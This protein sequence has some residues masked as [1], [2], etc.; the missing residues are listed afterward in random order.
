MLANTC[1]QE[2]RAKYFRKPPN[3]RQ[4]YQKLAIVSPFRAPFSE[5]LRD[6]NSSHA[7]QDNALTQ[8]FHILRDRALLQKILLHIQGKCKTFPP[9]IPSNSLIQLQFC[10][11]SRG[12][13]EDY[14]L[15]CLPTRDD[16]KRNLKQ[17]KKSNHEPVFTEPL[18]PD[19][20]E[21]E[22]KQLRQTH[23]KLLKRL[24]ARRVREKRKLQVCLFLYSFVI[25]NHLFAN[26]R[27]AP[28]AYISEPLTQ[29]RL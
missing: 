23:K 14:S 12:N 3:R 7:A 19:L 10:M 13:L 6:W 22:R 11:K 26:R 21:R 2:L 16:F 8:N 28:L 27:Q 29:R 24:R 5:L 4:N 17:I 25:C 20:A 1:H 15:I 18:L 9:E